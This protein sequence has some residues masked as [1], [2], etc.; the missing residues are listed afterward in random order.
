MSHGVRTVRKPTTQFLALFVERLDFVRNYYIPLLAIGEHNRN[1]L[2]PIDLSYDRR[3][4]K[5]ER[6]TYQSSV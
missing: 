5:S 2:F 1:T 4:L 3:D 6:L